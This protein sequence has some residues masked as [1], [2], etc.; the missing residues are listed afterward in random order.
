VSVKR[1]RGE[2]GARK[3][4]WA[5]MKYLGWRGCDRLAGFG[6]VGPGNRWSFF[7]AFYFLSSSFYLPNSYFEFG[8]KFAHTI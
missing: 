7:S 5:G 6:E 4:E 1:G 3:N 2:P 8:L